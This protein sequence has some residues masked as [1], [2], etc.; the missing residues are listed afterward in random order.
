M[1]RYVTVIPM[2]AIV[3]VATQLNVLAF[4]LIQIHVIQRVPRL[5]EQPLLQP[6]VV[7]NQNDQN[8][9]VSFFWP[10]YHFCL[11]GNKDEIEQRVVSFFWPFYHFCL[12]GNKNEIEQREQRG[13]DNKT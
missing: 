2:I 11:V 1:V 5:N 7:T 10:F 6:M 8:I 12:V 9:V 13:R 3:K 4:M